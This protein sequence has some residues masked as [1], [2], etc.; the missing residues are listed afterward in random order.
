MQKC[1]LIGD[2]KGSTIKVTLKEFELPFCF[3]K[4]LVVAWYEADIGLQNRV[5]ECWYL[6]L[7][8]S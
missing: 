8:Q 3:T 7:R 2:K 6:F 5:G 1:D 4:L